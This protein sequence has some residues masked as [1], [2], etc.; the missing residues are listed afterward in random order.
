ME[1]CHDTDA[2]K[3]ETENSSSS[4]MVAITDNTAFRTFS[5]EMSSEGLGKIESDMG[6]G[7]EKFYNMLAW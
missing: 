7:F 6:L 4:L 2:Y 5:I 3:D 1:S